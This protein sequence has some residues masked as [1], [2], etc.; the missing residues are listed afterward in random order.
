MSSADGT[1]AQAHAVRRSA[2]RRAMVAAM[3]RPGDP[4]TAAEQVSHPQ[5]VS[6]WFPSRSCAWVRD[7]V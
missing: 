1:S 6:T 4:W 3:A 7:L 2:A 5:R